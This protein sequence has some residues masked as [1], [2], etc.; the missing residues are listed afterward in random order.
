MPFFC[1]ACNYYNPRD[2]R[3]PVTCRCSTRYTEPVA[4]SPN[5]VPPPQRPYRLIPRR[6]T[7][8]L[9]DLVALAIKPWIPFIDERPRLLITL[10]R[11]GI[12]SEDEKAKDCEK[13]RIRQKALNEWCQCRWWCRWGIKPLAAAVWWWRQRLSILKACR[14]FFSRCLRFGCTAPPEQGPPA[15]S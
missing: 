5:F 7:L 13:C 6:K 10:Q 12:L 3:Y 14:N 15:R 11:W 1:P 9:G 2:L 4:L 8:G